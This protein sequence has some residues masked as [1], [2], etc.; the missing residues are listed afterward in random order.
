MA[1]YFQWD[2]RITIPE[3]EDELAN[4]KLQMNV[5]VIM[6]L[7]LPFLTKPAWGFIANAAERSY[8]NIYCAVRNT[9]GRLDTLY[10]YQN[11]YYIN[12]LL[13]MN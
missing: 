8:N 9:P 1:L 6:G 7:V 4:E 3:C 5:G 2:K 13:A 10:G 12:G 11:T